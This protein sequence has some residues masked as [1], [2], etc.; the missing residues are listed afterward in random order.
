M[1]SSIMLL[2][3]IFLIVQAPEKILCRHGDRTFVAGTVG[4]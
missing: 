4:A 3:F 2:V 1:V